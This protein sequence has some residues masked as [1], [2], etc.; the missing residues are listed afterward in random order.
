MNGLPIVV[1]GMECYFPDKINKKR[2]NDKIDKIV[3]IF[4]SDLKYMKFLPYMAQ[5][6]SML[7]RKPSKNFIEED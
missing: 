7:C 4:I 5:P 6:K 1:R 3:I 2:I